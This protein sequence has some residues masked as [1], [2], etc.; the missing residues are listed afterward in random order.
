MRLSSRKRAA[1][2]YPIAAFSRH[3]AIAKARLRKSE[4]RRRAIDR[5]SLQKRPKGGDTILYVNFTVRG[6][7]EQILRYPLREN[8]TLLKEGSAAVA[9]PV[10]A[11]REATFGRESAGPRRSKVAI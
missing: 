4:V 1:C 10:F 11:S 7:L 5:G 9:S 2:T 3:L 6:C 8:S